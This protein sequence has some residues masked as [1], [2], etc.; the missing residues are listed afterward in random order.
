MCRG[1][2]LLKNLLE[3]KKQGDLSESF[4]EASPKNIG[5]LETK[6]NL[7]QG[8]TIPALEAKQEQEQE[9]I[10]TS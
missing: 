6:N 8:E 2:C 3:L 5:N 4:T 9:K 7:D 10:S 1:H